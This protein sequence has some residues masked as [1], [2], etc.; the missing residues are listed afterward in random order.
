MS[1][2]SFISSRTGGRDERS[3]GVGGAEQSRVCVRVRKV[4]AGARVREKKSDGDADGD[5]DDDDAW[6]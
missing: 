2:V 5:G 1:C 6:P 4:K 3:I